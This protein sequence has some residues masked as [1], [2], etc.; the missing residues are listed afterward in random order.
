[1]SIRNDFAVIILTSGRP[2]KQY[3]YELLKRCGYTG[4]IIF[5]VDSLDKTVRELRKR[6][7]DE[8][9]VVFDK[10]T[11]EV[12]LIDNSGDLATPTYAEN[13]M[14][15]LAEKE[16]LKYFAR[17]DDDLKEFRYRIDLGDR[18]STDSVQDLDEVFNILVDFM[19]EADMALFGPSRAGYYFGGRNGAA[20]QQGT[21]YNVSQLILCSVKHPLKFRGKTYSDLL[22]NLDSSVSGRPVF[23]TM[24]LSV[25]SPDEGSNEGGVKKSYDKDPTRY[26]SN[27]CAVITHPAAV[28][29]KKRIKGDFGHKIILNNIFPK[30]ISGRYK[31]A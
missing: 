18:L 24:Y 15:E 5:L 30:I 3:T 14:Y 19:E 7:S 9:I 20:Y 29:I 11:V 13:Y 1:M 26:N 2:D 28:K 10:K 12:D 27:F 25:R 6:Y 31:R 23:R 21:D 17:A 4:K 22:V 16:G 8:K